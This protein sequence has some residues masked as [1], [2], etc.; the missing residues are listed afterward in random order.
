MIGRGS[1]EWRRVVLLLPTATTIIGRLIQLAVLIL[2]ASTATG[3][4]RGMLIAG[5]GLLGSFAI[6][7]DSGAANFILS[8]AGDSLSRGE[9]IRVVAFHAG[10]ATIGSAVAMSFVLVSTGP[11]ATV[12]A[13]VLLGAVALSQIFDG[14][15][16]S[17]RAPLLVA[18]RDGLFSIPDIVNFLA[19]APLVLGAVMTRDLSWLLGLPIASCI[20]TGGTF[21][22]V[23]RS[24]RGASFS[25]N[26]LFRRVLEFGATGS[27]SALYSQAPLVIGSLVLPLNQVAAL[28]LVYRIVQPLE[29]VPGTVSQQLT[30]RIRSRPNGPGFYWASFACA[31]LLVSVL[32]LIGAP[33]IEKAVGG[34]LEPRLV[35]LIIVGS[36]SIKWGNYALVAFVMGIGLVRARFVL[37]LFVGMFA[38]TMSALLAPIY[39]APGLAAVTLVSEVALSAGFGL[40]FARMGTAGASA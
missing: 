4:E 14:T 8:T 13:I 34:A 30:P 33:L 1:G 10:L 35:F 19:K 6:L 17:V 28:A 37:T 12:R 22:L 15:G 39:G 26:G 38:V 40:L 31:G 11:H 27:L 32:L 36:I 23:V 3:A 9:Y 20:V 16:R 25:R 5:I 24:I 29:M 18:R 2:V 7:T 21:A